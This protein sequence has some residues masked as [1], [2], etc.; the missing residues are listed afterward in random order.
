[1]DPTEVK[2]LFGPMVYPS[3][4]IFAP[5]GHLTHRIRGE[6]KYEYLAKYI[7]QTKT[8]ITKGD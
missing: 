7:Q 1:M 4:Y 5:D 3:V 8:D 6:T 2:A